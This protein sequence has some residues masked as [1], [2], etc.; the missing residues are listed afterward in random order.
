MKMNKTGAG[1]IKPAVGFAMDTLLAILLGIGISMEIGS[2]TCPA[3][4]F[5]GW[6]NYYLFPFICF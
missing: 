3:G 4:E 5:N 6:Y 1:N 2:Y